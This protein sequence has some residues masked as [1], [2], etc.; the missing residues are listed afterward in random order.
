VSAI[1][2]TLIAEPPPEIM[3]EANNFCANRGQSQTCLN[4]AE[5]QPKIMTEGNN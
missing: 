2:F 1:K 5:A 3:S 4:Y